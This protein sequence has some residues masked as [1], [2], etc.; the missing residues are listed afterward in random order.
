MPNLLFAHDYL[1]KHARSY[2]LIAQKIICTNQSIYYK[3]KQY[4]KRKMFKYNGEIVYEK[5]IDNEISKNIDNIHRTSISLKSGAE[6]VFQKTEACVVVDINSKYCNKKNNQAD[7]A[8]FINQEAAQMIVEQIILKNIGGIIIIDFID[9][10]D[11]SHIEVINKIIKHGLKTDTSSNKILPYNE[12]GIVQISRQ[13][14][15]VN[16][17]D[18][19]IDY[20]DK[21]KHYS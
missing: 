2:I 9:M 5:E 18:K 12:L 10:K 21:C 19:I 7:N 1:L 15:G 14:I 8:F 4:I 13:K 3:L 16:M 6:I 20:C 11:P 17:L